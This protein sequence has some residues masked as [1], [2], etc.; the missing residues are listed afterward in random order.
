[1]MDRHNILSGAMIC[2]LM[3]KHRV[4]ITGLATKHNITQKRVR[5][6]RSK[7][8]PNLLAREW[9]FLITGAW[10]DCPIPSAKP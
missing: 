7:G 5:E 2:R 9:V 1:M 6:V 3:R 4:T 8:V 10:P